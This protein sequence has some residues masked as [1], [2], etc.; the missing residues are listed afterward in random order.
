MR[1]PSRR[2]L[3]VDDHNDVAD[4]QA[5]LLRLCG[6]EVCTAY[7]GASALRMAEAFRPDVVF[8]DVMMPGMDGCEV[9]RRLRQLDSHIRIVALTA[10]MPRALDNDADFDGYIA[11]PAT[12]REVVAA[13]EGPVVPPSGVRGSR[14]E[15]DE[16]E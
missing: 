11:K 4:M 9:S 5:S 12:A 15:G 1:S 10:L 14:D 3:V 16:E 2:V 13:V 8:L 6:Y 7:D